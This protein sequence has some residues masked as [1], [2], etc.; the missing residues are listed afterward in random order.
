MSFKIND[1]VPWGRSLKEYQ[2]MFNLTEKDVSRRILSCADG[3]A[4]F[5]AE[6]SKLNYNITSLDPIYDF[7]KQ[8]I[9]ERFELA[10]KEVISQVRLNMDEFSWSTIKDV[11]Q[12]EEMRCHAFRLFYDDLE[13]GL[14]Q[15]RYKAGQFPDL[16]FEDDQFDLVLISHFLLLYSEQLD[17]EFHIQSIEECLR[18]AKE[19]RIFPIFELGSVKSRH[20]GAIVR[21]FE[22][23]NRVQMLTVKY[24][25][26][27]GANQMLKIGRK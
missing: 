18:V 23:Y 24:E 11:K 2:H 26:Q 21:H 19:V 15:G 17:L 5:N 7:D 12:L 14:E 6:G 9:S 4:S 13:Q 1:V 20:L 22:E 3:P 25:F 27:K 10:R 8:L 16:D